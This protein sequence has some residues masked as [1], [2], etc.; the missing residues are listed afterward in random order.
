MTK[1][2]LRNM[3]LAFLGFGVMLGICFP[4]FADFFVT[5][6][7]GMYLGFT[8]SCLVAGIIMGIATFQMMKI[9]LIKKLEQIARV[10][11]A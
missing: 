10:A 3:F 11:T 2:I 7:E 8:I 6:K 5:W 9:M 1:S 4:F